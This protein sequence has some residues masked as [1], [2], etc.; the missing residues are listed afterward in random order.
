MQSGLHYP[1][2]RGRKDE[3]DRLV[4]AE[5]KSGG[6]EMSSNK[7]FNNTCV[8]YDTEYLRNCKIKLT[9]KNVFQCPARLWSEKKWRQKPVDG[10]VM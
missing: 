1:G 2:S 5:R 6:G 4:E 9:D 8:G 3:T 10:E 7:C